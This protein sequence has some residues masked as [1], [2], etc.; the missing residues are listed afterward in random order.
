MF[1]G[2]SLVAEFESLIIM[3]GVNMKIVQWVGKW[4]VN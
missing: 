4:V 3:R 2:G 1:P